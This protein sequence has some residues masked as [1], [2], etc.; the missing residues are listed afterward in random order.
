MQVS[1]VKSSNLLAVAFDAGSERLAVQFQSRRAWIYQ[2]VPFHTYR[3]LM[4]AD[5]KGSYF[6]RHIRGRFPDAELAPAE[7]ADIF[8]AAASPAP[9]TE[10]WLVSVLAQVRGASPVLL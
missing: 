6:A 1:S 9:A 4:Q 3:S 7:V 10:R 8:A 5:S 2:C